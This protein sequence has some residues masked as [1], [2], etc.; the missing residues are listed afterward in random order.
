MNVYVDTSAVVKLIADE[1]E[2]DALRDYLNGFDPRRVFSSELLVTEVRRAAMRNDVEQSLATEVLES[3][4]LFE[5]TSPLLQHAGLLP[6]PTL[7][8]LDAIHLATALRHGADVLV[9]YDIRL[10]TA[11]ERQGLVAMSPA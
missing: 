6:D 7:R 11:A 1:A 5:M 4:S 9:C 3:I 8:S 2:S 10:R